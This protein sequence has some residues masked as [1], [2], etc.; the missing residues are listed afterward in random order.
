MAELKAC[1]AGTIAAAVP[2]AVILPGRA[3]HI[4]SLSLP[5]CRSEV[6]LNALDAQG[7]CVSKSSA[8]K[9]GK[10]SHVLEAMSLPN[11]VIDGAIRVSFSR[12]TTRAEC[13]TFCAEL[14]TAAETL[15]PRS[16]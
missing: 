4:L 2:D 11:K 10:R 1:C 3:P 8:C 16:K 6:L 14:L 12:Y 15:F 9:R 5:G 13:E 7:I